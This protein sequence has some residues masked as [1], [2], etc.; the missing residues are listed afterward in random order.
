MDVFL[1]V[2]CSHIGSSIIIPF[3]IRRQ[4]FTY[5]MLNDIDNYHPQYNV[6]YHFYQRKRS[7]CLISC[8][9]DSE[10]L[11]CG[12]ADLRPEQSI[13]THKIPPPANLHKLSPRILITS[14]SLH[15]ETLQWTYL[16][17]TSRG[18]LSTLTG[19]NLWCAVTCPLAQ[20][21]NH[22]FNRQVIIAVI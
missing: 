18:D 16:R 20:P 6:F 14:R 4:L 1:S 7:T 12:S 2:S 9:E 11:A 15:I 17:N 19:G 5:S 8:G 3:T 10:A 13:S 22:I 21:N